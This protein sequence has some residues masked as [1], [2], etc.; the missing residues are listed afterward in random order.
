MAYGGLCTLTK[1]HLMVP[2]TNFQT[3][4]VWLN[5]HFKVFLMQRLQLYIIELNFYSSLHFSFLIADRKKGN[6][7]NYRY[8]ADKKNTSLV[9]KYLRVL[10]STVYIVSFYPGKSSLPL[11]HKY[12]LCPLLFVLCIRN[13]WLPVPS[14][15]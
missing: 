12:F 11:P 5:S 15:K 3:I 13:F 10:I 1:A 4:F 9:K 2:G 8:D 14:N 6:R 7:R